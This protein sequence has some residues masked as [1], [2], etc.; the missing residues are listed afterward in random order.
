MSSSQVRKAAYQSLGPFISTFYVPSSET[1]S[2]ENV[3]IEPLG[4]SV[5]Q[6]DSL[7]ESSSLTTTGNS[8][9]EDS[10]SGNRHPLP[11]PPDQFLSYSSTPIRENGPENGKES[12]PSQKD[13]EAVS[14]FSNF[15]FW[16]SPIPKVDGDNTA[17]K[18]ADSVQNMV[19]DNA[20][21]SPVKKST[22]SSERTIGDELAK[23]GLESG[24]DR[25]K[26]NVQGKL[27]FD[28]RT[29]RLQDDTE[30]VSVAQVDVGT[31]EKKQVGVQNEAES[32]TKEECAGRKV[33][34]ASLQHGDEPS[35]GSDGTLGSKFVPDASGEQS[36]QSSAATV[37][38]ANVSQE[39]SSS[40]SA[41]KSA[42]SSA[43]PAEPP[44]SLSET[45]KTDKPRGKDVA[46]GV[47]SSIRIRSC[48]T[49]SALRAELGSNLMF[50]EEKKGGGETKK[51]RWSLDKMNKLQENNTLPPVN[52]YCT[53]T[54]RCRCFLCNHPL[55]WPALA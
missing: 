7:V 22:D 48:S 3:S 24:N 11:N 29:D 41:M 18:L 47:A 9:T 12:T 36:I 21:E 2:P 34:D 5:L 20:E 33:Q 31:E 51:R 16:R 13:T 32:E 23:E 37:N 6:D 42:L 39:G 35:L 8:N 53:C 40:T 26:R 14:Q 30:A 1:P 43:P 46:E 54:C 55:P 44:P 25:L 49:G 50:Q 28:E 15:E 19:L 17:D 45:A 4:D 52:T 10:K 38:E 27:N